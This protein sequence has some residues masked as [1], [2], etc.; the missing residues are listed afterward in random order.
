MKRRVINPLP[1]V[2]VCVPDPADA[3]R[4]LMIRGTAEVTDDADLA[5]LDWLAREHMGLDAFPNRSA[6][7]C[8][9]TLVPERFTFAGTHED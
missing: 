2:A 6:A 5:F 4:Y 7:R 9:I 3:R 1:H 8:V